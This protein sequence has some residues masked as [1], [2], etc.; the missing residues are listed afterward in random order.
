MPSI[1]QQLVRGEHICY[2]TSAHWIVLV[3]PFAVA[4]AFGAPGALLIVFSV[5]SRMDN[6]ALESAFVSGLVLQVAACAVVLALLCR[7]A[8]EF[9]VTSRRVVLKPCG[10]IKRRATEM[11]LTEI[12]SVTVEQSALGEMLDYGSIVVRTT[13]KTSGP[14]R[15][16]SQPFEFRRRVEEE[17]RKV[18]T[19]PLEAAA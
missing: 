18:A 19:V 5:A 17:I 3:Y 2:W 4:A 8:A 10:L 9:V 14:F 7:A 13:G 1:D 16:I 6:V 15:Y 12:V 11:F